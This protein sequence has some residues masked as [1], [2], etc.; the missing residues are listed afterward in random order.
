MPSLAEI[1][2]C[3]I[4]RALNP[5][6]RQ[7]GMRR[8]ASNASI[9]P[10]SRRCSEV[11]QEASGIYS[12]LHACVCDG[13][14]WCLPRGPYADRRAAPR[15]IWPG[16]ATQEA[17]SGISASREWP[18]ATIG[19]DVMSNELPTIRKDLKAMRQRSDK[20]VLL[21]VAAVLT[22]NSLPR[23]QNNYA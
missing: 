15:K 7:P 12:T 17:L 1:S 5:H 16:S 19:R 23:C 13:A 9:L 6:G 21:G 2:P 18:V 20:H 14:Q 4:I 22:S 10:A 3:V 8:A 11:V